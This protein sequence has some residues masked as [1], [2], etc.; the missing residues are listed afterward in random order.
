MKIV[1]NWV[2]SI[3]IFVSVIAAV[4]PAGLEAVVFLH[5][6]MVT[7]QDFACLVSRHGPGAVAPD[8]EHVWDSYPD[9]NIASRK[10]FGQRSIRAWSNGFPLLWLSMDIEQI[11]LQLLLGLPFL[12]ICTVT[13]WRVRFAGGR[14]RCVLLLVSWL[15][16]LASLGAVYL[17]PEIGQLP[18][19]D[20]AAFPASVQSWWWLLRLS[21][22]A[23]LV[24]ILL[25]IPMQPYRRMM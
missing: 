11:H 8:Q 12:L 20:Q 22:L 14:R 17:P 24:T 5:D 10:P 16:L 4:L 21:S 23:W 18:R 1:T 15:M 13:T 19:T 25:L 2:W 7:G 6:R 3:I 9:C